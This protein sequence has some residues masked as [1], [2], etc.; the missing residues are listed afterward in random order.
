MTETSLSV[1]GGFQVAGVHC[2]IKQD[3]RKRD[4][5]LVVCDRPAV[6]AGV[7]TQNLIHA[8]PVA[9]DRG[10]TPSERIRVVVANS[11]NANACTGPRG[12]TDAEQ[13]ARWAAQACGAEPDQALVLSTG[14]I[15]AYLPM[16]KIAQ[17]IRAAADQLGSDDQA[18]VNAAKGLMTTD[19]THKL[20]GRRVRL[21]SRRIQITGMA[22]GAG[23]IGPNMATM[24]AILMTDAALDKGAAQESLSRCVERTFNCISVEGHTSTNDSVLLLASGTAGGGP[25]AGEELSLFQRALGEVCEELARAIPSDGEGA[26][27]LITIEVAGCRDHASAKQIARTVANSPLVKTAVAGNDPNWGRIVSAVG[28]AGVPLDPRH[29]RLYLNGVLLYEDGQPAVFD[30]RQVSQSMQKNRETS[31]RL[32]LAEGDARGRF[33]TSDLTAEYIRI[34]SD[35]RT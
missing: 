26:S 5:T 3:P 21:D 27:H 7:Y 30:E 18:L 29:L 16:E 11:G 20:A 23:M 17:G 4:L 33:W 31:I 35:Y 9:L 25:L 13:M 12:M 19:S 24:L 8:A 34:N 15:G 1:P 28:Y 6:A 14:I 32:E 10:R 22:K 2:G